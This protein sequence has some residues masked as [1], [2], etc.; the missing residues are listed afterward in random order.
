MKSWNSLNIGRNLE[1]SKSQIPIQGGNRSWSPFDGGSQLDPEGKPWLA[2]GPS[3][4]GWDMLVFL[5][6][7][8]GTLPVSPPLLPLHFGAKEIELT[9]P[10]MKLTFKD[11]RLLSCTKAAVP[12][13]GRSNT[14]CLSLK[15]GILTALGPQDLHLRLY[16][17]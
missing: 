2:G 17:V 15:K 9:L 3:H 16:S 4:C 7:G 14:Q 12:W 8:G 10:T 1:V 13:L 11:L 5:A 6:S